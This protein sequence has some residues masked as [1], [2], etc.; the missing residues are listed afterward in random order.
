MYDAFLILFGFVL[1]HFAAISGLSLLSG[2]YARSSV[3]VPREILMN[4]SHAF[5]LLSVVLAAVC[6]IVGN[7]NDV[8][9]Y[10]IFPAMALLILDTIFI[11]QAV[12]NNS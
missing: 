5:G 4:R 12:N 9:D 1:W 7:F 2:A 11:Y 8:L 6:L 3:F 10:A